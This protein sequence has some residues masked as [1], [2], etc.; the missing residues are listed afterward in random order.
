MA[1]D[2]HVG[3]FQISTGVATTT[4][5]VTDAGFTPKV[6]IF[7][8]IG[9][10]DTVDAVGATNVF[11][12]FGWC[13]SATARGVVSGFTEN[14]QGT[15]DCDRLYWDSACIALMD[16][17]R[18]LD[19]RA[20]LDQ[21]LANGF[22]LVI[23]DQFST[24]ITIHYLALGGDSITDATC[25]IFQS[26]ADLGTE[27]YTGVGFQPDFVMF[28][29][30]GS[31]SVG[32]G[33]SP[34]LTW[35]IGAAVSASQE[36]TIG[37]RSQNAVADFSATSHY[38]YSG[39]CTHKHDPTADAAT[40]RAQFVQF[41]ADGFQLDFQEVG[42][43]TQVF[44]LAIKGGNYVVGDLLTQ[45]DTVTDITE[46]GFG[47]TPSAAMF[48]SCCSAESAE[49]TPT[50][51]NKITIG[52][53][54]ALD[55]RGAEALFD[56][57]N[58]ATSEVSSAV[59]FDAVYANIATDATIDGLMDV[60]SIDGGGFTCIMDDADPA[61]AFVAYVAFGPAEEQ[62]AAIMRRPS[63]LLRM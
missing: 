61:Q 6:L 28:M 38:I 53:F 36:M 55:E 56:E 22:R 50:A 2:A 62:T 46:S 47:F 57:D 23:D 59:E 20:D 26:A 43:N 48:F 5:D 42:D 16:T 3:S 58:K 39:E 41:L 11:N 32:T 9:R 7:W 13:T 52:A 54:S 14:G 19:G 8:S 51:D 44:Y 15:T 24:A 49:D 33:T 27:D 31:S 34:H 37:S 21:F 17:A 29:T 18:A 45:T 12:M 4:Q 40:D 30:Y 60:K 1:M 10:T 25:G 35:A 63:P